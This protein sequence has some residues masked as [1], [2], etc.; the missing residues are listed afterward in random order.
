MG[1][2]ELLQELDSTWQEEQTV[3]NHHQFIKL[4][5]QIVE[6][7]MFL[8]NLC[9]DDLVFVAYKVLYCLEEFPDNISNHSLLIMEDIAGLIRHR[10]KHEVKPDDYDDVIASMDLVSNLSSTELVNRNL[11]PCKDATK[12]PDRVYLEEL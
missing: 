1:L 11:L 5:N 8:D 2:N 10:Y 7:D 4:I 9:L 3:E 12:Q 6:H